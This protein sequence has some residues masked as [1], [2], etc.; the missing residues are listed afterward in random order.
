MD[1]KAEL[2]GSSYKER[3]DTGCRIWGLF[4]E[5]CRWDVEQDCLANSYPKILFGQAR[6]ACG[7]HGADE[8]LQAGACVSRGAISQQTSGVPE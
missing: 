7:L 8:R 4:I 6:L 2:D 5:G 3:P 1:S